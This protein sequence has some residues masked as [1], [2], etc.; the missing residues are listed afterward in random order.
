MRRPNRRRWQGAPW[1]F[2]DRSGGPRRSWDA[3]EAGSAL[4][5][6]QLNQSGMQM[7]T[8]EP[9]LVEEMFVQEASGSGSTERELTLT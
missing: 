7:T 8:V 2:S 9:E 5:P 1:F 4:V 6:G 3:E